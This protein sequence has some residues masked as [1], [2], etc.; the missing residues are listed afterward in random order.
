LTV[1]LDLAFERRQEGLWICEIQSLSWR[2][3]CCLWHKWCVHSHFC[4]LPLW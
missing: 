2:L 3:W 1:M 4:T